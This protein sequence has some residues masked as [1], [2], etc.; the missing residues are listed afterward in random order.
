MTAAAHPGISRHTVLKSGAAGTFAASLFSTSSSAQNDDPAT[1]VLVHPAWL[2]GWCWL[3]VA[4]RLRAHAHNVYTPTLT[5]LG[6]RVHLA[7]PAIGLTT[8]IEDIVNPLEFEYLERVIL[9]GNSSGGMVITGVAD[10]IPERLAAVV[11]LDAFVPDDGQSLVDLLSP[12]RRQGMESLVRTEGQGWL[13]PRFSL[14]P[15]EEIVRGPWGVTAGEDVAWML[16]RLAPTPFKH[17]TDR[18]TLSNPT[19]AQLNRVYIRCSLFP[20]PVFDRHAKTAQEITGWQYREL[21]T[22]HLPCITHPEKLTEV[23]L[24]LAA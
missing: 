7:E 2:G 12:E 23:L 19:T 22:P 4:W 18:V 8:H 24:E 17:F 16:S 20:Q 5:G 3:K 1:F 13:L 15:W 6:E 14:P 9:V 10:R 21:A 11:Y